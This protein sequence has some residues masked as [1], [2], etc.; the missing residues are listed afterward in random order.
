MEQIE[1]QLTGLRLHGMS[2]GWTYYS[3]P[4]IHIGQ[5]ASVIYTRTMVSVFV[6][7]ECVAMQCR[8]YRKGRYTT[9][10]ECLCSTHKHYLDHSPDYYMQKA[11]AIS[12]D[13]YQLFEQLFQQGK[14]PEQAYRTCDRIL[15]IQRNSDA[16]EFSKACKLAIEY[17]KYSYG[18]MSNVL[19]N[20]MAQQQENT[21][22]KPLPNHKNIRGL[23]YY[24]QTYLN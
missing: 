8:D 6:K 2:R 11:K 24:S 15:R 13:L 18:F 4:F 3:V 21:N 23:K 9:A 7:G 12:H 16:A 17:K 20:K 5:Q 14:Y 22:E 1:S 10:K 19:K